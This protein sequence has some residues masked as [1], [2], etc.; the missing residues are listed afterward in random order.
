M[1]ALENVGLLLSTANNTALLFFLLLALFLLLLLVFRLELIPAI[2][3]APHKVEQFE[4]KL[5]D[6]QIF[7]DHLTLKG[8]LD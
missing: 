6:T 1:T 5:A 2:Q 7:A 3:I 4:E 8:R